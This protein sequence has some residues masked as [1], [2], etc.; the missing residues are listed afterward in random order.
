M[1]DEKKN[2][3]DGYILGDGSVVSSKDFVKKI[4]SAKKVTKKALVDYSADKI[5][6]PPYNFSNLVD[7]LD[8]DTT[9][10]RCIYAK[11][12]D[13][14]GNG[15]QI[16]KDK[17]HKKTYKRDALIAKNFFLN[18]SDMGFMDTCRNTSLD[19]WITGNGYMEMKR[20][21]D[22]YPAK[23]SHLDSTGIYIRE[24]DLGYAKI[25]DSGDNRY[26]MKYGSMIKRDK[27]RI[28]DRTFIDPKTGEIDDK[29]GIQNSATE[30][31]HFKLYRPKS[32]FYGIPDYI[33]GIRHLLGNKNAS[34]YNLQFFENNAVPQYAILVMGGRLDND[35]SALIE[36]YFKS[37]IKGNSHKTLVLSVPYKDVEIKFVPLSVEMKDQSFAD[38][39]KDN[40][41]DIL[42]AH[43]VP[44]MRVGII[45]TAQLGSGSGESQAENYKRTIIEPSQAVFEN[46][47]TRLIL[48]REFG[49]FGWLFA[50]DD[51]D[52]RD[53]DA[54]SKIAA[55]YL[56]KG[57]ITLNEVR[58]EYLGVEPYKK[59]GDKA[60][61]IA[62]NRIVYIDTMEEE[63]DR[64]IVDILRS[65]Y[66]ETVKL[67]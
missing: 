1:K 19:F 11:A 63:E 65:H 6:E 61:I 45:E 44:P 15:W 26:Y 62:G 37:D 23:L 58:T 64:E 34:N 27:N 17:N 54:L 35:L 48:Q 39:K 10:A 12:A 14:A 57:A 20:S 9:H 13:L 5:I 47:L 2:I 56:E 33:S 67:L 29:L 52:F 50:F 21:L 16:V 55:V 51:I 60:F 25:T 22:G 3:V 31:M 42:V 7:L 8:Q 66:E 32:K 36:H 41:N 46:I 40:R 18:S 24:D 49:I 59:G 43:G 4:V 30:L 53:K 28:V 38:Y